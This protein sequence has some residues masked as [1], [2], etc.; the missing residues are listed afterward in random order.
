M[1]IFS[2]SARLPTSQGETNVMLETIIW[3]EALSEKT[4]VLH[5]RSEDSQVLCG[6]VELQRKLGNDFLF[7]ME[8]G[9]ANMNHILH[10]TDNGFLMDNG[11]QLSV[12]PYWLERMHGQFCRWTA[13]KLWDS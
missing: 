5:L 8:R 2:R 3:A 10:P 1:S 12:P 7:C 4:S 13:Q 9:M 6:I 11:E